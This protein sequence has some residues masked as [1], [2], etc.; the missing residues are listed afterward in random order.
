MIMKVSIVI[1]ARLASTR[2]PR[3]VLADINGRPMLW[4]VW[5]RADKISFEKELFVATDSVE[6]KKVVEG[7]GGSVIMTSPDCRSGTQRIV[8][9]LPHLSGELIL[10]VQGDEPLIDPQLLEEMVVQWKNSRPDLITAVY[11]IDNEEDLLDPNLVKVVRDENGYAIYFSR[12][13]IPYL[14]DVPQEKWVQQHQYWGHIGVY[15]YARQTLIDYAK[16]NAGNLEL[17]E[18][19]EQL[20]FIEKNYRIHAVETDYS[21]IGVDTYND[22]KKVRQILGGTGD[23]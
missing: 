17:A 12:S 21:P 9:I 1:P 11:Q 3:K 4:H 14:R 13:T 8:S 10:N 22:L 19:L 5:K 18:S 2:L 23:E 20:R 7:W 15:G 16:M 6:V